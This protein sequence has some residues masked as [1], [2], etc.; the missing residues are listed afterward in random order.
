MNYKLII[1]FNLILTLS[2]N[3]VIVNAQ[4]VVN[5]NVTGV[6][7]GHVV[8]TPTKSAK[9]A[10][11]ESEIERNPKLKERSYP[12]VDIALPK[13]DDPAWH[14]FRGPTK[15]VAQLLKSF[16]GL[17]T[18]SYPPDCNGTVGPN[19][20][21]QTVNSTYAIYDKVTGALLKNGPLSNFFP[22]PTGGLPGGGGNDGDPIVLYDEI[23][24]RWLMSEFEIDLN[25]MLISISQTSDPTG[26]WD[27][28]S[29]KMNGAPDYMKFG[30]WQDGYYMAT[31]TTTSSTDCDVYVFEKAAMLL[32]NANPKFVGFANPNK[33]TTIDGFHCLLPLDNDYA[34]AA[35]GSPGLFMTVN[36]DAIGGGTD[37]LWLYECAVNWTTPANSTFKRAQQIDV[38]PFDS[39]FGS[40]WDNIMQP[41]TQKLD[42]IP[43]ILM[44]RAQYINFPGYQTIMACHTVDVNNTDRAGIRWYEL[45]KTTGDWSVRQQNTYS[46]DAHSR[47][48]GS[49]SMNKNGEIAI[50]YSISSSTLDPGIRVAGQS[51]S[52]NIA[53][54]S[55]LDIPEKTIVNGSISQSGSNRWGDY[56]E[57]SIDPSNYTNFWFT[58]QYM[59]SDS[60]KGTKIASFNFTDPCIPPTIEASNFSSP[61][62]ND[63]DMTI[64]WSRGNGDGILIVAKQGSVVDMVPESGASYTANA[65]FGSGS[66]IGFGNYVV[67][68]GTGTSTSITGLA[69]G[70]D[71]HYAFYEYF[72]AGNCYTTVGYKAKAKTTGTPPY[73]LSAGNTDYPTSVTLVNFNTI[74]NNTYTTSPKPAAYIDY[75]SIA[76]NLSKGKTYN[77]NV[78]VNTG[79][80]YT[81]HARAWID[82]NQNMDFS[83]N[84]ETYDLGD[85]TNKPNNVTSLCPLGITIPADALLGNTRMRVSAE[86]NADPGSC[87]SGFDGEVED[88]TVTVDNLN[89]IEPVENKESIVIYPNPNDGL[90]EFEVKTKKLTNLSI[91]VYSM[92]GQVVAMYGYKNVT[93]GLKK[94]I[95]LRR[96]EKGIYQLKI[97]MNNK[98]ITKQIVI[99]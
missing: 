73:C 15:S 47:W 78:K 69:P 72:T 12:F 32:G 61:T 94:S 29:F 31:N 59:L 30:I 80:N 74:N 16:E 25:Y 23:E 99:E 38:L 76:T 48:M 35:P 90:F 71:Y 33:P 18:N 95:D 45:R 1:G 89:A 37:Q 84:G 57:M 52:S 27:S 75:T 5:P 43:Q 40:G 24:Q 92:S 68:N 9:T 81:V 41:N 11:I 96:K 14:T 22:G 34:Q 50:G 77:L 60:K 85:V 54:N 98:V 64:D 10:I 53:A 65:T 17:T 86:W 4:V 70:T 39:N 67:Y 36:D 8:I 20:Y 13:G 83:D 93:N 62:L 26:Q 97:E 7:A 58:N 28:Y 66:Q 49:I 44:F 46:P 88:Y 19:H 91:T 51:I 6:A 42:G 87:S 55:T 56:S 79:G 63:N 21:F 2:I 82:W 3:Y